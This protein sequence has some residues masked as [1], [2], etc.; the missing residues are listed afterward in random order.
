MTGYARRRSW[1]R[2]LQNQAELSFLRS[3]INPHFLYNSLECIRGMALACHAEEIESMT[4]SL[5][6]L[7]R[8]ALSFNAMVSLKEELRCVMEYCNIM[9]LRFRKNYTL[10]VEVPEP[11]LG[12]QVM[13]MLL[14]PIVENASRA[15]GAA[16]SRWRPGRRTGSCACQC[17]T[18]AGAWSPGFWSS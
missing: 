7:Y 15:G 10:L 2:L 9:S 4:I 1:R 5:S 3:Q 8:Y 13:P 16:R 17:R 6:R 12:V 14:Q 11:L 18:T